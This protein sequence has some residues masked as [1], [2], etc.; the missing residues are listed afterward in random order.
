MKILRHG[1]HVAIVTNSRAGQGGS[2]FA[3]ETYLAC[4]LRGIPAILATFDSLRIYPEYG[5]DL[6]RLPTDTEN[7]DQITVRLRTCEAL[8][9]IAKEAK[10]GHKL[11]I[12][13][14]KA[15]FIANDQIFQTLC[16]AGLRDAAS[17]AALIPIQNGSEPALADL[18]VHGI[19][20]TRGL[21]RHWGFSSS[22]APHFMLKT[23]PV[24]HWSP[25]FLTPHVREIIF[26]IDRENAAA[27]S[28]EMPGRR[29][30]EVD[31]NRHIAD[32]ESIIWKTLLD[33]ITE[34]AYNQRNQ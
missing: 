24:Y 8:L 17:V 30:P 20:I 34:D 26:S 10:I 15:S 6:R 3:V 13:D 33:P 5:D 31:Y 2:L 28:N 1:L 14:T 25:G 9:N 29:T 23:P 16:F 7:P 21:F 11:L 32:A 19:N 4:K 18:E 12:I 27:E 22:S